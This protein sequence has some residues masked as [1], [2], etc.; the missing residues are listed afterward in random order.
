MK[1][2]D[3][4][5]KRTWRDRIWRAG[6]GLRDRPAPRCPVRRPILCQRPP[7]ARVARASRPSSYSCDRTSGIARDAAERTPIARATAAERAARTA[8]AAA[9]R[10]RSRAGVRTRRS[11]VFR[12]RLRDSRAPL[13]L[14]IV[15]DCNLRTALPILERVLYSYQQSMKLPS[16]CCIPSRFGSSWTVSSFVSF[17]SCTPSLSSSPVV[18]LGVYSD[19]WNVYV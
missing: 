8:R 19:T 18:L 6:R 10:L 2:A 7:S 11:R 16:K 12:H 5:A 4:D 14:R 9:R 3:W 13:L 1:E 15:L 17:T